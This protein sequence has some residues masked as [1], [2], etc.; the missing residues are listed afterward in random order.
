M[1]LLA[2]ASSLIRGVIPWA[3]ESSKSDLHR[4][5]ALIASY[6]RLAPPP[7][8]AA[9]ACA[10]GSKMPARATEGSAGYDL[11]SVGGHV[12]PPGS[13]VM[14]STGVSMAI[15]E[16]HVGLLCARS[17]LS[18]KKGLAPINAPGIIDSDYRGE[19]VVA[20][21]NYGRE[22]RFI[23]AGER[24]AQLVITPFASPDLVEYA[25]LPATARGDGG[26]GSTGRA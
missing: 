25:E 18:I 9:V 10:A 24:I 2:T 23:E 19:I 11:S 14:V 13:T 12:I 7:E 3:S 1:D 15:P 16:G 20:L 4:A 17:G 21:H 26:L 8:V 22:G 6:Q 5:V